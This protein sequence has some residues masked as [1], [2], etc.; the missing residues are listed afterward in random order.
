MASLGSLK[1]FFHL[2]FSK[3]GLTSFSVMSWP[4]VGF[5]SAG[6]VSAGA[7]SAVWAEPSSVAGGGAFNFSWLLEPKGHHNEGFFWADPEPGIGIDVVDDSAVDDSAV[8]DS[9]VDDS[10][11][12]PVKSPWSPR[13]DS[14]RPAGS[15]CP[16]RTADMM[17]GQATD[18]L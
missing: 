9:A 11:V 18:Q 2:S 3:S 14:T 10:A 5:S 15:V 8:D 7:D 13:M 6:T 17:I 16:N 4:C 1:V 12:G